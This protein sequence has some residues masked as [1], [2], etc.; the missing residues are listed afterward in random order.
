MYNIAEPK[1]KKKRGR[2]PEDV[3]KYA[4][5]SEDKVAAKQQI[6]D[7]GCWPDGRK[8]TAT[9]IAKI[10]NQIS[11]QNVR[12]NAR[13]EQESLKKANMHLKHQFDMLLEMINDEMPSD[14]K[15]RLE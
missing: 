10:K 12:K 1:Q 7:N 11:V 15:T 9:D 8:L 2:Q 14:C 3:A 5:Q 4:K 13:T 6:L